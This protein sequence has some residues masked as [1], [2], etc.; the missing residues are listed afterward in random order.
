MRMYIDGDWCEG[1]NKMPVVEPYTGDTI[2]TVPDADA[3]DVERTLAAAVRRAR[4]MAALT[5]YERA[6]ILN[7]AADQCAAEVETLTTLIAREVGKPIAEARGEAGRAADMLRL[8]AFEGS[9]LRGETLPLDANAATTGKLG[10]TLRHPCGVVV[11]ITPFNYPSLLVLHKIGPALATGNAVIL[12][13]ATNTPLTALALTRIL[14]E[15]GLPPN[16]LQ[17]ITGSGAR[18]GP[19]LCADP[20]VRNISFTGSTAVGEAIAACAGVKKLSLELGSACPM[21]VMPDADLDAVA[22]ATATAGYVNA[23]QVCISL[24]RVLVHEKVYGDYLDAVKAPVEAIKVGGSLE[25]D[26]QLSAMITETEAERVGAWV[27]EAMADGAQL[28]TGGARDGA[29][30]QPTLLADVKPE[31]RVFKD[32]VFGPAVAATPVSD[33]DHAIELANDSRYG[34]AAAIFTQDVRNAMRF[35]QAAESGN[36][37]VNWT[38]LWRAD[39]MP[40]GGV[41]GSGFGKEGIRYAAEEMTEMKTVVF[42]GLD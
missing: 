23:G 38:P 28:V 36:V 27:D 19:A 20:R 12:K 1:A 21:V 7:R 42:H 22:K 15:D 5:A 40:Y 13:P 39:L 8:A 26:T 6:Q 37:H 10:F 3:D 34:L 35:A 41:K 9:Q 24:Q 33:I 4:E 2:D 29:V 25:P 31:M 32:E 14:L 18:L 11:A 30:M 17:C 16:A